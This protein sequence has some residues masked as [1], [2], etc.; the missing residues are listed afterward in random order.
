MQPLPLGTVRDGSA[1]MVA[2]M[3][4]VLIHRVAMQVNFCSHFLC[5][6][7]SIPPI[8]APMQHLVIL[9]VPIS[10]PFKYF[11]PNIT[12]TRIDQ[13]EGYFS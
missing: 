11:H 7:C 13:G 10:L 2:E 12:M 4:A 3:R 6:S 5:F 1:V 9:I 8:D